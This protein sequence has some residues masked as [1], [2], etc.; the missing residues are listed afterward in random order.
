MHLGDAPTQ[1]TFT[2]REAGGAAVAVSPGSATWTLVDG[3]Q[4][5]SLT[6]DGIITAT[7]VG[8]AHVRA[9][10]DGVMSAVSTVEVFGEGVPV[11]TWP[12]GKG[13]TMGNPSFSAVEGNQF[14]VGSKNIVVTKLG[15]ESDRP[16]NPGGITALFNEAG[17][18]LVQANISSADM[19]ENGYYYKAITP[20][21]LTAGSKYYIGSL[22]GTGASGSCRS[23]TN[24]ASLPPFVTDLGTKF[25]ISSTIDG[26]H[27]ENSGPR[28]YVGNFKAYQVP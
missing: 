6:E 20:I 2:A 1:L 25:K 18:V 13:G 28:H 27:W 15:Y 21:T 17:T 9:T 16:V 7:A 8:V 4:F 3:G 24:S 10:V 22:H 12:G 19:L 14:Q 11:Y 5:V 23:E 26:G